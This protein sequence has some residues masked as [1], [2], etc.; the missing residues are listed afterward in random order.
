MFAF[1]V[2]LSD[3]DLSGFDTSK[4]TNM[5]NMFGGCAN[6]TSLDVS[7]FDTSNVI[8]MDD[9]FAACESLTEVDL[10][11]FDLSKVN[12][13]SGE[14][15]LLS[16]MNAGSLGRVK[17]PKNLKLNIPSHQNGTW[18]T[19]SGTVYTA[20]PKNKSNSILLLNIGDPSKVVT[21]NDKKIIV[22]EKG[23][24]IATTGMVKVGSTLYYVKDGYV[25]NVTTL[26]K[27]NGKYY[28][29]KKGVWAKTT[30]LVKYKNQWCYVKNGI[31][32]QIT[33]LVKYNNQWWYVKNGKVCK[34]A[35]LSLIHI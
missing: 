24:R 3:L 1:C 13:S 23:V 5:S 4:V 12:S 26:V 33:S 35:T 32:T 10:S 8:Q 22:D 7:G 31:F 6:L 25:Q 14:L 28:Y 34:D 30:T 17:T 21:R 15:N 29:V 18:K 20:L 19:A 2:N 16:Y 9:M 27:H 11:N